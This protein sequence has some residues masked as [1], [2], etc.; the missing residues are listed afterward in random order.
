MGFETLSV[1]EKMSLVHGNAD[2][3]DWLQGKT[4]IT[5]KLV[6]GIFLI[7]DTLVGQTSSDSWSHRNKPFWVPYQSE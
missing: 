7:P 6:F 5:E 1:W 4:T 3:Y 2:D